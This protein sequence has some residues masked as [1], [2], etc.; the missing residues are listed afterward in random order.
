VACPLAALAAAPPAGDG[1][2]TS[3]G[4]AALVASRAGEG[5]GSVALG[6]TGASRVGRSA[7]GVSGERV[8]ASAVLGRSATA[9]L[10]PGGVALSD[11]R[12]AG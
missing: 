1:V 7:V 4:G 8:G 10:C 5:R 11:T 9:G 12:G 3:R 6:G 2:R